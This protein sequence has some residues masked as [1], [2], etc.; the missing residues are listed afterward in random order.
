MK[1]LVLFN[2]TTTPFLAKRCQ[3]DRTQ[4][5]QLDLKTARSTVEEHSVWYDIYLA[6]AKGG[7][8]RAALYSSVRLRKSEGPTLQPINTTTVILSRIKKTA[9]REPVNCH[10]H[11]C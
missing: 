2:G 1:T 10:S 9:M 8:M 11:V 7:Q 4:E 5:E 6:P 3:G